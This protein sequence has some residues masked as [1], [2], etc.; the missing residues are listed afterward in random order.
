MTPLDALAALGSGPTSAGPS[1]DL[2][3]ARRFLNALDPVGRFTF[4]TFDDT[5][6]KRK[7]LVRVF[8]GTLEQHSDELSRLNADGAGVFVTVNETD[9]CGRTAENVTRVRAAFVDL[10]GA[11]LDPVEDCQPNIVVESSPGRWHAYWLVTDLRLDQFTAL[12]ERLSKKFRADPAVKDLPRVMR[13]PGFF[14][15]KNPS[16]FRSCVHATSAAKPRSLADLTTLFGFDPHD[17]D[18]FDGSEFYASTPPHFVPT[19]EWLRACPPCRGGKVADKIMMSIVAKLKI[20]D[21]RCAAFEGL[22]TLF[23]QYYNPRCTT[24]D[25]KTLYPWTE[26]EIL[27]AFER[28]HAGEKAAVDAPARIRI[29][30]FADIKAERLEWFWEGYVPKGM[31]TILQGDGGLGKSTLSLDLVARFTTGRSMPFETSQKPPGTA[32]IFT[33][34]DD[35]G[36]VIKPRLI[37]AGA[38][39]TRVKTFFVPLVENDMRE[40]SLPKDVGALREAIEATGAQLAILDPLTDFVD[41]GGKEGI[42]LYKAQDARAVLT[43]ITRLAQETGCTFLILH[44]LNKDT[45]RQAQHRGSGSADLRNAVRSVLVVGKDPEAPEAHRALVPDKR[46]LAAGDLSAMR[47]KVVAATASVDGLSLPTSRVEW[48]ERCKLTADDVLSAPTSI[49]GASSLEKAKAFLLEELDDGPQPIKSLKKRAKELGIEVR[50]LQR[51][52]HEV[53]PPPKLLPAVETGKKEWHWHLPG[54]LECSKFVG[55][56]SPERPFVARV[57]DETEIVAAGRA[58]QRR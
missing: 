13:L 33:T 25:G 48:I 8:H 2:D 6:A 55:G 7:H 29:V 26:Q 47:W 31:A 37:A 20:N 36:R 9:L 54:K 10:D 39:L 32:L 44:H 42:D 57:G 43:P 12:Q 46:N 53:A 51:A 56:S 23:D 11:P 27:R 40:I 45:S 50:T 52:A 58:R 30:S 34:E 1:V 5:K 28:A 17:G 35:K 18:A 14:H 3:E 49:A 41:R 4:Q 21:R 38:D 24:A 22:W 16:E 19:E 15:R